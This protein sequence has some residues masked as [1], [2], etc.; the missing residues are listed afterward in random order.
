[1]DTW[2]FNNE[3]LRGLMLN[4]SD[5]KFLSEVADFLEVS[6]F[7]FWLLRNLDASHRRGA[8]FSLMWRCKCPN[9]R[10]QQFRLFSQS[11]KHFMLTSQTQLLRERFILGFDRELCQR[12]KS[13]KSIEGRHWGIIITHSELVNLFTETKN[14]CL[15]RCH[16][17]AALHPSLRTEWFRNLAPKS[18]EMA[19]QEAVDKATTL[20]HHVAT[21]YHENN[22]TLP[23]VTPATQ[24]S[25]SGND[26]G[27]LSSMLHVEV[28]DVAPTTAQSPDEWF[29][30]ELRCYL[31]FEGGRGEMLKP[32]DWWKVFFPYLT[33]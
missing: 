19:H 25:S 18:N 22:P 13:S 11:T 20:L 23:D 6:L 21:T 3:H 8:R 10:S 15:T 32:L 16:H 5:W 12:W 29:S 24:S 7:K 30:N 33:C 31:R 14:Y 27:F 2:V 4:S 26:G 28:A 9:L 17:H 1:M